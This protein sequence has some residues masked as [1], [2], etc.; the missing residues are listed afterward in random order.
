MFCSVPPSDVVNGYAR[1][2]AAYNK[3]AV[4]AFWYLRDSVIL[5]IALNIKERASIMT[6]LKEPFIAEMKNVEE[7][8]SKLCM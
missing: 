3:S 5:R 7:R 6:L 8:L 4:C 1:A 2:A